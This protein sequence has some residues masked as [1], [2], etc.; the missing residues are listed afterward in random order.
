[1]LSWL[2]ASYAQA[3]RD[4]F[5]NYYIKKRIKKKIWLRAIAPNTNDM[6]DYFNRDKSELR[7]TKLVSYDMFNVEV[8]IILYGK[9]KVGIVSYDEGMGLII[10]SPKIYRSLK[11]IFELVWRMLPERG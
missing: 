9:S 10:E 1:M 3:D 6:Q 5:D 7:Q 4:F 2:P 8:G 11:D